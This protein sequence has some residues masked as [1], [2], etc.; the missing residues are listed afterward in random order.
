NLADNRSN[1]DNQNGGFTVFGKVVEGMDVINA[2]AS[3]PTV[4]INSFPVPYQNGYNPNPDGDANT[5]PPTP[6]A[7]QVIQFSK[8][9]VLPPKNSTIPH[10]QYSVV[11]I[12]DQ[13][14]DSSNIVSTNANH[15][16]GLL[17]GDT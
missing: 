7:N 2:I 5:P 17:T 8:V 12:L 9:D 11:S 15:T 16:T 10:A 13:N 6:K 3:L 14:G 4:T 1:L